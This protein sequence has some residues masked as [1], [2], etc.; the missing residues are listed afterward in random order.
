MLVT[1]ERAERQGR[2]AFFKSMKADDI[3]LP[4][5]TSQVL[6][7]CSL[8]RREFDY[9]RVSYRTVVDS[10]LVGRIGSSLLWS[11][12]TPFIVEK[13]RGLIKVTKKGR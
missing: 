10:Y 7:A 2:V 6:R 9:L 1:I 5:S 4:L 12:A 13:L 3:P 11:S 8:T